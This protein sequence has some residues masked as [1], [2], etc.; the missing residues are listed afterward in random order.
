MKTA[1][2]KNI[3]EYISSFPAS[4]SKLLKQVRMI[5]RKAAPK[6]EETISY[7][8]PAFKY[9]G[10][11]II[12]FAG[13][14]NHIGVYATPSAHEAFK[15][16]LSVYKQ[17]KGSVQFPLVEPLPLDLISRMVKFR[18]SQQDEPVSDSFASLSAPARRALQSNGIK[19]L[20][21]LSKY[22]EKEILKFHG[23]GKT[24]IPVLDKALKEKGMGFRK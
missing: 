10:R 22:S 2:A 20:E 23:I 5:V 1:P 14:K 16:E 18:V 4:T 13:Y 21:H 19:T 17:G 6:A 9:K 3:D 24:T 7:G 12:Y 15:K 11:V 8:M